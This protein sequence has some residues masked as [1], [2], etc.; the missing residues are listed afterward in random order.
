MTDR[1]KTIVALARIHT[2]VHDWGLTVLGGHDAELV[3]DAIVRGDV[4][5]VGVDAGWVKCSERMPDDRI[6][7]LA[8]VAGSK[9]P[10][11]EHVYWMDEPYG[12]KSRR[13]HNLMWHVEDV[14]Y[15][16]ELPKGSLR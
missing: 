7:C 12:W 14:K 4:P 6:A 9:G 15:W 2:F 16:R 11:A 5:G 13:D 10:L 8:L 3:Y 1:D